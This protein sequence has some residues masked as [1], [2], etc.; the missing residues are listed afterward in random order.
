M[1]EMSQVTP[2][3]QSGV[4]QTTL[5]MSPADNASP[6]IVLLHPASKAHMHVS[7][8]VSLPDG[9]EEHKTTSASLTSSIV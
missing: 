9:L 1:H 8:T 6:D 2:L 5:S 4:E 3:E 7:S